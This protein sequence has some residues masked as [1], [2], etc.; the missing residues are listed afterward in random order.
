MKRRWKIELT[1]STSVLRCIN[2][3]SPIATFMSPPMTQVGT[4]LFS[5]AAIQDAAHVRTLS[6]IFGMRLSILLEQGGKYTPIIWKGCPPFGVISHQ[7]PPRGFLEWT[8]TREEV[9]VIMPTPPPVWSPVVGSASLG[10]KYIVRLWMPRRAL[11]CPS[12]GFTSDTIIAEDCRSSK[13]DGR[14][15]KLSHPP[16]RLTAD[17]RA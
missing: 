9:F 12:V 15:V 11:S 6:R 4:S 13:R 2:F 16:P 1:P 3:G 7:I 5:M 14:V 17:R 10:D 8:V